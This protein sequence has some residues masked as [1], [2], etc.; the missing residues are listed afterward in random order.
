MPK[1]ATPALKIF[2]A[3][4]VAV[5][6]SGGPAL[7]RHHHHH[8]HHSDDDDT[9]AASGLAGDTLL[10]VRHA[11]KPDGEGDPG[12]SPAGQARA[13]A[14]ADYFA[15]FQLDGK[16]V[17]ID[18]IIATADSENSQRPRLTV[19]P[20]SQASGIKIQQ[21]FPDKEVKALA[22][23]LAAGEPNRTILIAW[24][25]GKLPKLLNQLGADTDELFP[26]GRWPEDVYNWVIVLKYDSDGNL[27]ET[28][29][30]VEPAFSK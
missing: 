16:P 26:D 20:F 1:F 8:H 17:K 24:H 9:A 13:K 19:T 2:A 3:L 11:D 14:Y 6:L 7:A 5:C 15:H 27:S 18:T 12:L 25:H 23:W 4:A 10:I 29:K 22:H 30:I 28:K 21:P